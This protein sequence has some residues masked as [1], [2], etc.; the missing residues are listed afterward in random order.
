VCCLRTAESEGEDEFLGEFE[1]RSA[2]CKRDNR[3]RGSINKKNLSTNNEYFR[4]SSEMTLSPRN[5]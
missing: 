4:I 1:R 2:F 5:Q 3:R